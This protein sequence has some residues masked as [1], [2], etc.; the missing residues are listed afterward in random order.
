MLRHLPLVWKSAL[1]N[2]RRSLLTITSIAISFCLLGIL[3]CMYNALYYSETPATVARRVITR[4]AISLTVFLPAS[5]KQRIRQIPGVQHVTI[6]QWFGGVYKDARDQRNFFARFGVEPA[7]HF[8]VSP[9]TLLPEDQ[10]QAFLRERSSCIA[11][12]ELAEKFGWKIGEKI[13]L[14]GD[15]FAPVNLDLTLRGIFEN[16]EQPADNE[17][18]Y[19]N[20]EYLYQSLPATRR[21]FAGTFNSLLNSPDDSARVSRELDEMFRNSPAQTRT[22]SESAFALSFVSFLGNVKVFLLT[23][24]AAVVFTVLLVSA[25]TMAMAVR[26]RVKE[27]GVLKTLGFTQEAIL[28]IL[29]MESMVISL[30]GGVLGLLMTSFMVLGVRNA[31]SFIAQFKTI[32]LQ[33]SSAVVCLILAMIV[34]LVSSF[35]PAWRASQANIVDSMKYTG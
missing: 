12:R 4:N 31:G 35:F 32:S 1:R 30:I 19:F 16:K 3:I 28:G 15:I 2:K 34:G 13:L 26:E 23:I 5:Y 17:T 25:N 18:L 29:L 9:D 11:G 8:R 6:S 27:V 20:I 14:K 10:K 24:C 22:E 7:E 21:D 33:P